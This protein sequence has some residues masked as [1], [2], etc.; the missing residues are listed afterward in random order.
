MYVSSPFTTAYDIYRR[1]R[2]REFYQLPPFFADYTHVIMLGSNDVLRVTEAMTR[3]SI[4][5]PKYS[6]PVDFFDVFEVDPVT[7]TPSPT[8]GPMIVVSFDDR[9][10]WLCVCVCV[11]NIFDALADLNR[12]GIT[13]VKKRNCRPRV[14]TGGIGIDR[15]GCKKE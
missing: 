2:I 3:Y 1:V 11:D 13:S 5:G 9:C 7:G 12:G 8:F 6:D 15:A 14:R 4:G 10:I